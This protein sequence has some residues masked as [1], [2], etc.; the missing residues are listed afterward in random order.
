MNAEGVSSGSRSPFD[1]RSLVGLSEEAAR[2]VAAAH[3][4]T[5]RVVM[6]D[7]VRLDIRLDRRPYRANVHVRDGR[8]DAFDRM[9]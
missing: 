6:R 8:I 9:G 2:A 3:G 7:G 5:V 1:A 4:R